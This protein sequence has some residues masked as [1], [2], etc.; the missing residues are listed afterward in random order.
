MHPS[1]TL[2]PYPATYYGRAIVWL[3]RGQLHAARSRLCEHGCTL[4]TVQ[5]TQQHN[6]INTTTHALIVERAVALVTCNTTPRTPAPNPKPPVELR[7]ATAGDEGD[8]PSPV[9]ALHYIRSDH[10]TTPQH[11]TKKTSR[12]REENCDG[13]LYTVQT[14]STLFRGCG[15]SWSGSP[16]TV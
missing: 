2:Q 4:Y 10:S 13:R 7:P 8:R 9:T 15:G 16:N 11:G 14:N 6:T 1:L 12:R 3:W 5:S